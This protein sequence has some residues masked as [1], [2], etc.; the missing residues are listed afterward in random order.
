MKFLRVVS[1]V[2]AVSLVVGQAS[3]HARLSHCVEG[4]AF[5]PCSLLWG[6]GLLDLGFS[7]GLDQVGNKRPMKLK[8]GLHIIPL[9]P[10]VF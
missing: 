8:L 4:G 1:G 5:P 6:R 2:S 10:V 9:Y 7:N 3:L